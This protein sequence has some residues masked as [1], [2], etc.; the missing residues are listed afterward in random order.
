MRRWILICTFAGLFSCSE[1]GQA[2]GVCGSR[3]EIAAALEHAY[4]ERKAAMA[5]SGSG[6]LVELYM[7]ADGRWTLL[8]SMPGGPTCFLA[9]GEAWENWTPEAETPETK[10]H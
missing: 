5:L 6:G 8:Y 10:T 7:A 3:V 1:F 4:S 9:A 2:Q